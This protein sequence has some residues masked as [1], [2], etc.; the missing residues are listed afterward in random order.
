MARIVFMGT[1]DYARR[2]LQEHLKHDEVV[3]VI[4]QPDRPV[5]RKRV[6]TP[7][8]VKVCAKQHG[9][10]CLQ[11]ETLDA[12]TAEVIASYQPD[13]L[14]VAAYGQILKQE[15]LDI[16]T[17]I[18]LHASL[19][20][21]YRGASPLHQALLNGDTQTGV[22][23]MQMEKGLDSGPV[24]AYRVYDISSDDTVVTLADK[25]S[26][27]AA[28]L[29]VETVQRF[30]AIKPTPQP[31]ALKSYC[32]KIKKDHGLVAFD[33]AQKLY[34]RYRAFFGWPGI[35]LQSGLKLKNMRLE[36]TQSH[37]RAG[38]ILDIADSGARIGCKK[39]SVRITEVQPSGKKSM[40]IQSY[41]NGKR[42]QVAD[43]LV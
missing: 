30:D 19:L 7:P 34:N 20:P 10:C 31:Q 16:A 27:A 18:N 15:I 4:T 25:L 5:G 28:R 26:A 2:I 23:A 14:I 41:C 24:L 8:A 6:M 22:T 38:E 32:Y 37:N 36:E 17:P 39:G 11:P 35:Y 29:S 13:F 3:L 12:H 40:D 42:L 9:I 21:K 1:P 33:S 43:I